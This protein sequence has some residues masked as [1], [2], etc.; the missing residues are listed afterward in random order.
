LD[1]AGTLL[2]RL[3]ATSA[4]AAAPNSSTM[5]GAGTGAGVPPFDP[6]LPPLDEEDELELLDDDELDEEE[7]LDPPGN[8][9]ELLDED[10]PFELHDPLDDE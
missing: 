10:E 5:G 2:S 9:P 3:R 1:Q 6:E 4:A 7:L 8:P